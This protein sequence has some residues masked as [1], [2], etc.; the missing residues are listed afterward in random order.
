SDNNG[1]DWK[2]IKNYV[3]LVAGPN[4]PDGSVPMFSID[5]QR[6]I[7]RR[8]HYRLKITLNGDIA[9]TSLKLTHDSQH[10]QRALPALG[11]GDNTIS[12]SA[13]PNEGTVT[14]EP[15]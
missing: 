3:G 5:L 10:S 12:F 14:I 8:Y 7:F 6:Q 11:Q 1:L 13:G 15:A 4:A 9:I 2:E